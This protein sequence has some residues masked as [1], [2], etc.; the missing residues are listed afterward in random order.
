MSWY[1]QAQKIPTM[2]NII[3]SIDK[4]IAENY[5][6][7]VEE[8]MQASQG[9][10]EQQYALPKAAQVDTMPRAESSPTVNL[11]TSKIE[12][13]VLS[14]IEKGYGGKTISNKLNI[15]SSEVTRITKKFFPS[16]KEKIRYQEEKNRDKI[17][18]QYNQS[19]EEMRNDF[20]IESIS[21]QKIADELGVEKRLIAKILKN[22]NINLISLKLE[23][24]NRIAKNLADLAKEL[25]YNFKIDDIMAE[26][27]N[28]YGFKISKTSA[29]SLLTLLNAGSADKYDPRNILKAFNVFVNSMVTGGINAI[30]KTPEKIPLLINKFFQRY[31]EFHGFIPPYEQEVLRKMLMTKIQLR[32]RTMYDNQRQYTPI[33]T[34]E[35]HPSY[36]LNNQENPNE[37]V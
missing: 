36:F 32:D 37:L 23:R 26:F 28:R 7:S 33:V 2:E 21:T 18:D 6:F 31:G 20:S 13:T 14:L 22:N 29:Y 35:T 34:D 24:K 3:W 12:R 16:A 5:E 15:P 25:N 4:L 27:Y 11:P 30:R 19:A 1:K 10:G 17:L 9:S 8:L